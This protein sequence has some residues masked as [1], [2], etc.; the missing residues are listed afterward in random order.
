MPIDSSRQRILQLIAETGKN[1]PVSAVVLNSNVD[2]IYK[3]ILPDAVTCFR[4]ELESINGQCI[5]C[6]D[7]PDLYS[8]LRS[9]VEQA[10]FPYLYCRDS[11]I[12]GQ[13]GKCNIPFSNTDS[14][15]ENMQAG[16]TG[17]ELLIART[18]SVLVSSATESG[19]QMNV[20]P[21]V[22]I[23]LAHVSQL[24]NY[25]EDAYNAI[26]EKYGDSLPST[27]STITGP[28]RTADIE[29]TL[30]LGAHGPK[31]FVVFLCKE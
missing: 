24:V 19:R 12:A 9:F 13:L 7:E 6:E 15:F 28:S 3:P 21:P 18:G 29:K 1:R 31:E 27:I 30:V 5:L 4:N 11:Y 25:P 20:F 23:V 26:Q 10:K 17:C 2:E 22:H 8:R 14:D 16:I